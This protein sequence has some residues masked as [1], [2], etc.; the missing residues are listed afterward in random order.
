MLY[1]FKLSLKASST[2]FLPKFLS[3]LYSLLFNV[4]SSSSF[5][6][7]LLV[8]ISIMVT[9]GILAVIHEAVAQKEPQKIILNTISVYADKNGTIIKIINNS[10]TINGLVELRQALDNET[11]GH[12]G[13]NAIGLVLNN[14][15]GSVRIEHGLNNSNTAVVDEARKTGIPGEVHVPVLTCGWFYWPG[16]PWPGA[17]A[18]SWHPCVFI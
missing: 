4:A 17:K 7:G 14:I 15:T 5:V 16:L 1:P 2:P 11:K 9:V 18:P 8:L 3:K 6:A 13:E 12:D 10:R